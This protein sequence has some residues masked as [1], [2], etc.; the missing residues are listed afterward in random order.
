MT[1]LADGW[2]K[3]ESIPES[4]VIHIPADSSHHGSRDGSHHGSRH[5]SVR[6]GQRYSHVLAAQAAAAANG[7]QTAAQ[8]PL[9][10]QVSR[11]LSRANSHEDALGGGEDKLADKDLST[12]SDK[13]DK[14]HK[15]SPSRLIHSYFHKWKGGKGKVGAELCFF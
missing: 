10:R 2:P 14:R 7:D 5:G 13:A 4:T 8:L 11:R 1:S 12:S 6:N 15:Y 9:E 3:P